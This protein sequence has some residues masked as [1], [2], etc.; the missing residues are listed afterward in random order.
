MADEIKS[1]GT[2]TTVTETQQNDTPSVESLMA[3]LAEANAR[4]DRNK[5]E[6]DKALKENGTVKKA[7]REIGAR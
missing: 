4:A 6:L 5:L 2:E 1:T 3:Q 7:L